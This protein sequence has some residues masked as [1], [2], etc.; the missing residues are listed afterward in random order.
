MT[1]DAISNDFGESQTLPPLGSNNKSKNSAVVS[2]QASQIPAETAKTPAPATVLS[3]VSVL[4]SPAD[5]QNVESSRSRA[6]SFE[7]FSLG[8]NADE[9]L[10]PETDLEAAMDQTIQQRPRGDSI[11]F[12]PMSFQEG[13]IHEEKAGSMM[14]QNTVDDSNIADLP[15]Q[16]AA[17]M[18]ILSTPGLF[19]TANASVAQPSFSQTAS[20][21]A[22][23]KAPNMNNNSTSS[24]SAGASSTTVTTTTTSTSISNT[25]TNMDLLNKDGRIGIYLPE[26]RRARIAKF[27]SKR[28]MRIW[29]KRIKYDCR[30]KLADSRPRI[31]GRFVKRTDTNVAA[32][33]S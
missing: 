14:L 30:K 2:S 19:A 15:V 20:D 13:G 3:N 8:I 27:H 22:A 11:I 7:F 31:K 16:D 26:A 23:M 5:V 18:A 17:E 29:K 24:S 1:V 32:P 28:K 25:H 21:A 12:D 33:T 10:P 9:P 4:P 6:M